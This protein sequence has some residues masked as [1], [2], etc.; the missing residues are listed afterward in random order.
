MLGALPVIDAVGHH[1]VS[2]GFGHNCGSGLQHVILHGVRQLCQL[3]KGQGELVQAI[4]REAHQP[5]SRSS[6]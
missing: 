5:T 4:D 1:L 2:L 3:L 6:A